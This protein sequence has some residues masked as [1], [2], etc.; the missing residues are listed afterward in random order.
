MIY[1]K[2]FYIF[3]LTLSIINIKVFASANSLIS[4]ATNINNISGDGVIIEKDINNNLPPAAKSSASINKT[5]K[6]EEKSTTPK[7]LTV[8]NYYNKFQTIMYSTSEL[9]AIMEILKNLDGGIIGD[10]KDNA[11]ANT[12]NDNKSTFDETTIVAYLNSILYIS[13]NNWAIWVNGFKVSNDNNG[14][15]EIEVISIS[16][17]KAQLLWKISATKWSYINPDNSLS[18]SVYEE[19][20]D[21]VEM[22]FTLSPNQTF[23]PSKNQVIE[24]K[25]INVAPAKKTET[26]FDNLDIGNQIP[27]DFIF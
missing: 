26:K 22:K 13:Q 5:S 7:K 4:T 11:I 6:V 2:K 14:D 27:Q 25:I 9:S 21:T 10:L 20:G 16:P 1:N 15:G 17:D 23:V 24:G 8:N 3:I 19:K 18:Q 12:I